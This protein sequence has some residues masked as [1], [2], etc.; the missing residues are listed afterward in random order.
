MSDKPEWRCKTCKHNDDG[1]CGR[2]RGPQGESYGGE[3]IDDDACVLDS[4][5]AHCIDGS[6]YFAA[7]SVTDDF[8]CILWEPK[9][10]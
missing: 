3:A 9:S 8:G 1:R 2:L 7:L 6:D 10:D 5:P 4:E